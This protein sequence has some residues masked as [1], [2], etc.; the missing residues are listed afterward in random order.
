[1][2]IKVLLLLH[3]NNTDW[4]PFFYT[5]KKPVPDYLWGLEGSYLINMLIPN[6]LVTCRWST[7]FLK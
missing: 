4:P 7:V 5:A 2:K 6:Y 3:C 1:M